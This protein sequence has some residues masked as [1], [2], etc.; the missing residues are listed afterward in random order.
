M[1]HWLLSNM[2]ELALYDENSHSAEI[3]AEARLDQAVKRFNAPGGA[4]L[5]LGT[6]KGIGQVELN[7]T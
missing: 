2:S 4:K 1:Q 3:K 6:G 7:Q 5:T